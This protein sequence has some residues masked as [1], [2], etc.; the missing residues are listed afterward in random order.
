MKSRNPQSDPQL[1]RPGPD[2]TMGLTAGR[3]RV[4]AP[5]D[6]VVI[7]FAEMVRAIRRQGPRIGAEPSHRAADAATLLGDAMKKREPGACN[8]G[9]R[10]IRR[11][12]LPTPR[13]F[14]PDPEQEGR[15][16]AQS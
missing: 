4:G 15:T 2:A 6:P 10:V 13:R 8:A 16:C 7:A 5:G 9:P 3:L 12:T 1:V 14:P 11:G